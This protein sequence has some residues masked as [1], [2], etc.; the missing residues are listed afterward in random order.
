MTVPLAICLVGM[1]LMAI[2]WV[3]VSELDEQC[4]LL[5]GA[6]APRLQVSARSRRSSLSSGRRLR[7]V[8]V[9]TVLSP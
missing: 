5:G 4:G 2:L 6:R 1:A 7:C 8:A 3:S 9:C